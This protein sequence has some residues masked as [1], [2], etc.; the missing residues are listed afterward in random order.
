MR[1]HITGT[2]WHG[3]LSGYLASAFRSLGHT[4]FFFDEQG[5]R[6]CTVLKKIA[7]RLTRNPY[8]IDDYF[9]HVASQKWLQSIA[10]FQSDIIILEYA[11]NILPEFIRKARDFRKPILYWVTS[12]PAAQQ[13]KDLLLALTFADKIFFIDRSWLPLLRHFSK[14]H[15]LSY[16]PLAGDNH[17]FHPLFDFP[18]REKQR[19][20]DICFV[21][22]LSPQNPSGLLR[23]YWLN[24]IP[25]H[26]KTAVFG[27]GIPYWSKYFSGLPSGD[28]EGK[29]LD[30]TKLNEVYNRSKLVLNIHSVD[31]MTSVSA[32]TF[33]IALSG[34]FQ[35]VDDR[36]DIH[37]LFP[38]GTFLSFRTSSEML[39]LLDYW[40]VQTAERE[41]LAENARILVLKNHTWRHRAVEML[42]VIHMS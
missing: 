39:Q 26:Y 4:V 5:E 21:G 36:E 3:N 38:K 11:P 25:A 18:E 15:N 7:L 8:T 32:R 2:T 22:S 19:I 28:K 13:S 33:E 16:L 12:P 35:I 10:N 27:Q 14:N 41:R 17:A 34:G 20:Y 29:V 23:A 1:I 42:R 30:R 6:P 24:Q 37:T 31:H 40:I 9:R